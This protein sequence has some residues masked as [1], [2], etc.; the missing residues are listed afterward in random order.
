MKRLL[1]LFFALLTGLL[2]TDA[3]NLGDYYSESFGADLP[4]GE[5]N[6]LFFKSM[7]AYFHTH[8]FSKGRR[9]SDMGGTGF[10]PYARMKEEFERRRND[11]G[12]LHYT[13]PWQLYLQKQRRFLE[14]D[15]ISLAADWQ[16]VGT[17]NLAKENWTGRILYHAFDPTD[18]QTLWIGSNSGGLWRSTDGAENWEPMT[19]HL[20][21]LSVSTIGINPKNSQ[22]MLIGTGAGYLSSVTM[23]PGI[24]ILKSTD[25][26]LS[27]EPTSFQHTTADGVSTFEMVWDQLDSNNVYLAATNGVWVSRDAGDTWVQKFPI[28]T[29]SLVINRQDPQILYAAVRHNTTAGS[30]GG[31]YQSTDAGEN[32]ERLENGLPT[33]QTFGQ[34]T[35]AICDSFPEVLYVGVSDGVNWGMKGLY[36]TTDGGVSWE[37]LP[38]VPP[39]YCQANG[40]GCIG[41]FGNVTAVSPTNPDLVFAGGVQFWRSADGGQTWEWRDVLSTPSGQNNCLTYVDDFDMG[42][43]PEQ[44]E[45]CYLFNDGGVSKSTDSG[46]CWEA[47]NDG[48]VTAMIYRINST[49]ID[50][51]FYVAG[52]QDHGAQVLYRGNNDQ[53]AWAKYTYGGDGV[54]VW[55]D[56]INNWVFGDLWYGDHWRNKC[57][58]LD[59]LTCSFPIN[60]GIPSPA[61][62][63]AP[64]MVFTVM[65]PERPN[66]LFTHTS[67]RIY[68]TK[69]SGDTWVPVADIPNVRTLGID[70]I[71]T[72]IIYAHAYD[73][74]GNDFFWR[75]DDGGNSWNLQS[76]P[77]WRVTDIEANPAVS[78]G[79]VY[80]TRNSF[81]PNNPHVLRSEDYGA[82]WTD[83][84]NN[85]PD[86]LV[87]A[88]SINPY[89]PDQLY[90]AT[91]IGV[92]ASEDRGNSW[93]EFNDNLPVIRTYDLHYN[94]RDSTLR[95]ATIGRGIWKTK[96]LP[97]VD[98]DLADA[99]EESGFWLGEIFPNPATNIARL[100]CHLREPQ[101]VRAV[102]YLANGQVANRFDENTLSAG[103]HV[104]AYPLKKRNGRKLL[105]GVYYLRLVVGNRGQTKELFILNE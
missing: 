52:L 100:E 8:Y 101:R 78:D 59:Y 22:T 98:T 18:S 73:N 17:V 95:V 51:D 44:P 24:G 2:Y 69:N 55:I 72:N 39:V 27:W 21:A 11:R 12:E 29:T 26:G 23:Q 43:D 42:F 62:E 65:D 13:D 33:G 34:S 66:I 49:P 58:G 20:P 103:R 56:P 97:R 41:Y 81:F 82:T 70:P 85:L 75:S 6:H 46:F 93:Q 54:S 71:N 84:T 76:S 99:E 87:H 16:N 91:D 48:L 80:L 38:N 79:T 1:L 50:T 68:R 64:L 77:G 86:V 15:E 53:P 102:L 63:P 83:I 36:K 10:N 90:L 3:Q 5:R 4:E 31:V 19:D 28:R 88:I 47:A 9:T 37:S 40:T 89:D 7:D 104:L 105:S 94:F 57:A 25:G 67:S 96:A 35:L 32:W 74:N 30:L 14:R 45:V 60:N 92:W 61:I